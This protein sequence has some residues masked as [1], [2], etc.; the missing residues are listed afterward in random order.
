MKR[1]W[2]PWRMEYILDEK[3]HDSCLFCDISRAAKTRDKKNLILFRGGNCFVVLNRYPYNSGHLMVVPYFHTPTFEG[4]SDKTLFDFIKTID[5]SVAVLKNVL[6]PDGF[7][8]GLNFGKVAGAGM[9]Q[10]MHFHVVPRWTGDTDSMPIISETRVMPEHIVKT[11]A[12]LRKAFQKQDRN[13]AV[14]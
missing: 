1:L 3:K 14:T 11:Y 12:K 4:L 6:A 8:M 2:A 13:E 7:N 9:E 10:H 5:K